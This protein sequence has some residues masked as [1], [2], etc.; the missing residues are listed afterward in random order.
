MPKI[1]S[2]KRTVRIR[3]GFN[4][5][6]EKQLEEARRQ[7]RADREQHHDDVLLLR[8]KESE[9]ALARA[10]MLKAEEKEKNATACLAIAQET[11]ANLRK[12]LD[13]AQAMI[14]RAHADRKRIVACLEVLAR[15]A[16]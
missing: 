13:D 5:H 12:D 6:L 10:A 9:L 2:R 14:L 4:A 16:Q 3:T 11:V 15:G 7:I 1:S 8:N